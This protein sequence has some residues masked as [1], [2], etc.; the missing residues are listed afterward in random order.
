VRPERSG[1]KNDQQPVHRT[2]HESE[3]Q[4]AAQGGVPE[5]KR[6]A[7]EQTQL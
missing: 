5:T 4:R 7:K 3:E 2:S 6:Q 1:H